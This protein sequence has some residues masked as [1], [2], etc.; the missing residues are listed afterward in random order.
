M[1]HK[2][3]ASRFVLF[4][5]IIPA[6]L[7]AVSWTPAPAVAGGLNLIWVMADDLG[8][9]ELGCYGQKVIR[10]PPAQQQHEFLYWEFHERGV[11]QAA[12]YQGRWK[13]IRERSLSSPLALYDLREDVAEKTDVSAQHPEIAASIDA[14]LKSARSESPDWPAK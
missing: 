6:L 7:V 4:R 9:G 2:L 10:T 5:G 3:K 13:G 12:L 8:Y 1:I 11:S 14:Y